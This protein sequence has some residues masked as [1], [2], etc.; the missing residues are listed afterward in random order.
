L[1][2]DNKLILQA[3]QRTG[4]IIVIEDDRDD[5]EFLEAA[6]S[7]LD[8]PNPIIFFSN[9]HDALEYL[10]QTVAPPVL[11][12]SDINMPLINGFEVR[13]RINHSRK[14]RDLNI[15]FVFLTTGTQYEAVI[16][17]YSIAD[18]GFFTKPN[19]MEGLRDIIKIIVEYWVHSYRPGLDVEETESLLENA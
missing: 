9:G 5:Q 15:P 8:F 2:P 1:T 6:F 10:H 14:L 12:I 11:I 19:S 3:M 18:Q 4:P 13:Q 7:I 17:A 16:N